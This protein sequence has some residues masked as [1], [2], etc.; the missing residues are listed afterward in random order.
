MNN[1]SKITFA[2]CFVLCLLQVWLPPY[3]LTGDGP[4]HVYNA[5]VLHDI[6][7]NKNTDFYT[8]YYTLL[9]KPTPNWFSTFVLAILLFVVNGI[10]AEKILLTLYII[11]LVSGFYRLLQKV[12]SKQTLW[13]L[14]IFLFVFTHTL[15]KGFYNFSFSIAFFFFLVWSWLRFLEK[16]G[17]ANAAL[18]LLFASLLFFT[19]LISFVF[20]ALTCGALAVSYSITYAREKKLPKFLWKNLLLLGAFLLPFTILAGLF[21]QAHGG[22]QLHL[23]H[24]FYR[25]VELVQFKY[26]VN[27]THQED[28]FALVAGITLIVL[29]IVSVINLLKEKKISQY[30]GLL[31]SLLLIMLVYLFFPETVLGTDVMLGMRVQ[32]FVFILMCCCVAYRQPQ[33]AMVQA[34]SIVLLV[35]FAAMGVYRLV[36]T[37]AAADATADY[38]SAAK[39]IKA[40]S[41]VLPLDFARGGKDK[42]GKEITDRNWPFVHAAEYMG[43]EKSLIFL[44]NYEASTGFFPLQWKEEVNPFYHLSM[45]EGI[46][47]CPPYADMNAYKQTSGVT[48]DYVLMWCYDPVFLSNDHFRKLYGDIQSGYHLVYTSP[49]ARTQLYEKNQ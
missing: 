12:S 34:G 42:N 8:Q 22:M 37:S 7:C 17:L 21:T 2:A 38:T 40:G 33:Q 19:H 9:Y 25:L 45:Y 24:H 29:F 14:A 3:C 15:S 11:L 28:T 10:V 27:I 13:P 43:T 6:W 39:Y 31:A 30:D 32:L 49:S 20:G 23:R 18:F 46:E 1:L 48:I 26:I 16:R 41:V 44:D 35:C 47:G 5:Q 36:Y 4:C